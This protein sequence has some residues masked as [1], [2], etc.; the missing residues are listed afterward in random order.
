M[1]KDKTPKKKQI[2]SGLTGEAFDHSYLGHKS[3]M[4]LGVRFVDQNDIAFNREVSGFIGVDQIGSKG[5]LV[6]GT[7]DPAKFSGGFKK[8]IPDIEEMRGFLK[9]FSSEGAMPAGG[10]GD[11]P[12]GEKRDPEIAEDGAQ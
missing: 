6:A 4:N 9:Q 8:V 10:A 12:I 1:E 5:Y 3:E 7:D 2:I 11:D